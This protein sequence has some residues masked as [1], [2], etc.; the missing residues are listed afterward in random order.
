MSSFHLWSLTLCQLFCRHDS[1]EHSKQKVTP[2]S[3]HLVCIVPPGNAGVCRPQPHS[4]SLADHTGKS[5]R[6]L[7]SCARF[8]PV[9]YPHQKLSPG[10][11]CQNYVRGD[12]ISGIQPP[13]NSPALCPSL[14]WTIWKYAAPNLCSAQHQSSPRHKALEYQ[15]ASPILCCTRCTRLR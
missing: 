8:T 4:V 7:L 6:G 3:G 5:T 10:I 11:P 1:C 2:S 9:Q 13:A 15:G 14:L 12:L